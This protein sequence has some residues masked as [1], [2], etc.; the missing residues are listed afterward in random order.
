LFERTK[1]TAKALLEI[2]V[3]KGQR[4]GIW[5]PNYPEWPVFELALSMIGAIIVPINLR[6]KR[7]EMRYLLKSADI[8]ILIMTDHFLTNDYI[9]IIMELVP[10]INSTDNRDR[11]YSNEFPYLQKIISVRGEAV[12]KMIPLEDLLSRKETITDSMLTNASKEVH[13]EDPLF[14]FWTS[15]TTGFPKGV[16]HNHK[17][18]ENI[19]NFSR[20][21]NVNE[22]DRVVANKPW[23]YIAGNFWTMLMP[24]LS[25]ASVVPTLT[26]KPSEILET[27]DQHSVT[28]LTVNPIQMDSLLNEYE[29]EGKWTIDTLRMG[30]MG[31]S[32]PSYSLL[33]RSRAQ[34]QVDQLVQIY[35]MT[36]TQ[37][38]SMVTDFVSTDEEIV[39]TVGHLLPGFECKIVD[40]KTKI[41]VP[42]GMSGELWIRGKVLVHYYK[43]HLEEC[44][45]DG[46]WFRTGDLFKRD[47][48]GCFRIVGRLKDVI[49]V[50]GENV[51]AEEVERVLMTHPRIAKVAVLGVPD[52]IHGEVCATFY[53]LNMTY[54]EKTIHREELMEWCRDRMA[55]Y[56]VPR[57]FCE[58]TSSKDWPLTETSKIQK[59]KL[60][61]RLLKKLVIDKEEN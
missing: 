7:E 35:G 16:V 42:N 6:F 4:V 5:L 58:I 56:K 23:F 9:K 41:E 25:G 57:Y 14:I 51:A 46:G 20:I 10:Q 32:A 53:E 15:G 43:K 60:R 36:E 34:W 33:N 26:F 48:K 11:I 21:I 30:V 22:H 31:G 8:S 59:S 27:M 13:P 61:S 55:P 3:S 37:G 29:Q 45:E 17:A 1:I 40:P 39:T 50:G 18:C 24:L 54:Q 2:G 47:T 12:G 38:Y 49:K 28:I 44:F 52:K 19:L